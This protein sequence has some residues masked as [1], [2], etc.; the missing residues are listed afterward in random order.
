[1]LV[2]NDAYLQQLSYYIHRNPPTSKLVKNL[3]LAIPR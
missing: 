2:Q 1:M 3:G